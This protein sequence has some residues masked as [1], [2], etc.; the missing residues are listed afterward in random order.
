[1]QIYLLI[2]HFKRSEESGVLFQIL[3]YV[4]NDKMHLYFGYLLSNKTL[5]YSYRIL[6]KLLKLK[7]FL[8]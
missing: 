5:K 4:Q 7:S 3:R 2:C 6:G 1:M 8:S